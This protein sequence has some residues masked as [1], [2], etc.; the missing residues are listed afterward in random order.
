MRK[1]LAICFSTVLGTLVICG[2]LLAHHGT[3]VSYDMGKVVTVKGTVTDFHW[4]NPH[5]QLYFDVKD[6][7]GNIVHW[8]GE[9]L[10]PAVLGRR[11]FNKNTLKAGDQVTVTLN[12]SKVGNPVGVVGVIMLDNGT[13]LQNTG[14]TTP[15]LPTQT[16]PRE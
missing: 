13:V 2:S 14:R 4:A 15:V 10:S 12:P 1:T 6:E 5:V 9:M 11:G 7:Q 8:G 16:Q 3:G